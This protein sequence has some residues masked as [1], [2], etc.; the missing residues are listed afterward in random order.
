MRQATLTP[1]PSDRT[2]RAI[3]SYV[4]LAR[5]G[6]EVVAPVFWVGV[7]LVAVVGSVPLFVIGLSRHAV[8]RGGSAIAR[9][10][11]ETVTQWLTLVVLWQLTVVNPALEIGVS[12][13]T[14]RQATLRDFE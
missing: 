1:E 5:D 11:P 10:T 3:Q 6:L 8:E 2:E 13:E 4:G 14:P 7:G 9:R 12:S